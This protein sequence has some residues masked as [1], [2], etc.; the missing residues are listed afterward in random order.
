MKNKFMK[1]L[2]AYKTAIL[3]HRLGLITGE[4]LFDHEFYLFEIINTYE[5]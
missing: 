2:I 3:E 5:N 4:E 1:A